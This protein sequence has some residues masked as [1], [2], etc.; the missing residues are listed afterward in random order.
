MLF[1]NTDFV[2]GILARQW[3]LMLHYPAP[4]AGYSMELHG[5]N[6]GKVAWVFVNANFMWLLIATITLEW[7][8][9]HTNYDKKFGKAQNVINK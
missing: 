9:N 6:E 5:Q 2:L 7:K 8:M 4:S 3:S 1:Q